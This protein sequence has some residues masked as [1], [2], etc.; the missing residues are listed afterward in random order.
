MRL[1]ILGAVLALGAC[2]SA[3]GERGEQ[4]EPGDARAGG[5]RSFQVGAF[6]AVSLEGAHD[7]VVTVGGEPSVRAEGDAD[8]LERLEVHV[9]GDT[10][11]I[12]SRRGSWSI[13]R[14]GRVIVYVTA[15]ALRAASLA[16]AG[17]L[18]IDRVQAETFRLRLAGAGDVEIGQLQARRAE[19]A[20]AGNGDIRAAGAA[21]RVEIDIAGAGDVTLDGLQARQASVSVAGSGDIS[22]R[23]SESVDGSIMGSGNLMV[24]G[25][26][27]CSVTKLGSGDIRCEA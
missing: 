6:Q 16:G 26:A 22:L 2:T 5:Q 1:A 19:F 14:R 11:H 18:R 9:E 24:R 21:D 20:I 8:A 15:P 27:R 25:S 23:A 3:S 7:V 4:A 17:D 10:L 13:G 12:G